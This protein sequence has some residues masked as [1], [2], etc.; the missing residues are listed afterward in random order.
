MNQRL[1]QCSYQVIRSKQRPTE[2]ALYIEPELRGVFII[3]DAFHGC[4]MPLRGGPSDVPF[5]FSLHWRGCGHCFSVPC[6]ACNKPLMQYVLLW[7]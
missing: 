7:L 5:M 6:H 2:S 4:K 1:G 3:L